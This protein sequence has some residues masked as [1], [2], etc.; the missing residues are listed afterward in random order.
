MPFVS[1]HSNPLEV[2]VPIIPLDTAV[3]LDVAE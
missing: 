3:V 2:R 1:D